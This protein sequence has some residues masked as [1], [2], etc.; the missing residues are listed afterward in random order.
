MQVGLQ[1]IELPQAVDRVLAHALC[2]G[3]RPTTPVRLTDWP[4]LQGCMNDS[5]PL[6]RTVSCLASS[7]VGNLPYGAHAFFRNPLTPQTDSMPVHVERRSDTPVT[8][9]VERLQR[10]PTAHPHL[11]RCSVR[12]CPLFQLP[13]VVRLQRRRIWFCCHAPYYGSR[14]EKGLVISG[15][16]H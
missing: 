13:Q 6:R 2:G 15:T 3:H 16:Y 5:V 9:T 7:A 1:I 8:L 11:L 10:N 4:L 12:L 14:K